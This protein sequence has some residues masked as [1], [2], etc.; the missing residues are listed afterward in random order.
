MHE[1][2]ESFIWRV[3]PILQVVNWE[4]AKPSANMW[5]WS[6]N[7]LLAAPLPIYH[8]PCIP[9]SHLSRECA[10]TVYKVNN[11]TL[12]LFFSCNIMV[13]DFL[14]FVFSQVQ[15]INYCWKH[16][17]ER[18]RINFYIFFV[19][20]INWKENKEVCTIY[21]ELRISMKKPNI[22]MEFFYVSV[23]KQIIQF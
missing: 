3:G 6:L 5:C 4:Y 2:I 11:K 16:Y 17:V 23:Q 12:G 8:P 22:F 10:T 21:F 13:F 20:V 7:M 18:L 14:H 19:V 9:L 15:Y 1:C